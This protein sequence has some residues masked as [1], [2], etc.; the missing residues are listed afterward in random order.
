[1]QYA[2]SGAEMSR[3][4]KSEKNRKSQHDLMYLPA[5]SCAMS[6]IRNKCVQIR[7]SIE[8]R[9]IQSFINGNNARRSPRLNTVKGR[10]P[11]RCLPCRAARSVPKKKNF[12]L[13]DRW[14]NTTYAAYIQRRHRCLRQKEKPRRRTNPRR[15]VG[16]PPSGE[17]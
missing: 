8:C 10:R 3:E 17:A 1:M 9:R 6:R 11:P 14:V 2:Y 4:N 5:E 13:H 16:L 7:K 15:G 12:L